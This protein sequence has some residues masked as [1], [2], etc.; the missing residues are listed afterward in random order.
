MERSGIFDVILFEIGVMKTANLK[1]VDVRTSW[2]ISK[3]LISKMNQNYPKPVGSVQV[4]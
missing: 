1:R 2:S 3:S 4:K